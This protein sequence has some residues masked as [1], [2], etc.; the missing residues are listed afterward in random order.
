[1]FKLPELPEGAKLWDVEGVPVIELKD[2]SSVFAIAP[3]RAFS[4]DKLRMFR[5]EV[6]PDDLK[7]WENK[8]AELY[9]REE[10]SSK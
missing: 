2:G 5:S 10:S 6:T 9:K 7:F 8:Y 4:S 3:S 1:M